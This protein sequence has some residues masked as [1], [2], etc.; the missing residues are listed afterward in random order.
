MHQAV[1][2]S[3]AT[4]RDDHPFARDWDNTA[5]RAQT[6]AAMAAL[7]KPR[8]A[9]YLATNNLVASAAPLNAVAA[10][11]Q[12]TS[13]APSAATTTSTDTTGAP[14][15]LQRGVP[16]Q[17]QAPS[18]SAKQPT[19]PATQPTTAAKPSSPS[20]A[21]RTTHTS[22]H[23]AARTNTPHAAPLT[24]QQETI[25]GFTLSYGGLPT[26]VY[27]AAVSAAPA[28]PGAASGANP[29]NQ[30]A[31]ASPGLT[32]GAPPNATVYVTVVA[33]RLPSGDLQVALTS[34]TDSQHLDRTPRLRL[35]DAVDPDDSHRASLLFELRGTTSRQFALYR[36]ISAQA[37]QTFTT[38]SI[39]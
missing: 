5:E 6:L 36:L 34:V 13:P 2:V 33:Q 21:H 29:E 25:S 11:G 18:P 30:A 10:T 31:S 12:A 4:H 20:A 35:I 28:R 38:A 1:A 37:E 3:D 8:I 26:F 16:K 23:A 7:A 39:E 24:L 15:R 9:A 27:T 14:P 32:P 19:P 22:G 17:Y